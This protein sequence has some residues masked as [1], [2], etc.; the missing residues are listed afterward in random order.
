MADTLQLQIVTPDKRLVSDD[1]EQ[2][3]MPGLN[4]YLGILP[5]HA[6]LLTELGPGELSYLQGGKTSYLAVAWGF[7]EV[8]PDKVT[9]LA[10][11]AE[12]PEDIDV[13]RAQEAKARA[14]EALRKQDPEL[15]YEA[16]LLALRRADVRLAVAAR[17]GHMAA[18]H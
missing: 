15:D 17:A 8:L 5:G 10:D 2:V 7:A 6:P 12:R 13:K 3:E 14:E 18:A 9:I 1:V 11:A 4:G 16:T